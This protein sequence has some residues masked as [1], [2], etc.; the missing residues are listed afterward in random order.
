MRPVRRELSAED[1]LRVRASA[2][3]GICPACSGA[4][5]ADAG[6]GTGRLDDGLY[7]SLAC[8]ASVIYDVGA[9]PGASGSAE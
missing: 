2:E 9:T 4:L 7:C 1:R 8:L 3:A 5:R 6:V